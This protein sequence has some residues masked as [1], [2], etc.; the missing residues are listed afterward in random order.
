MGEV[1]Q[2]TD[3]VLHREVAVK[4]LRPEFA[5]DEDGLARFRAEA[6]HAGSL[7]HP[8][9]AHVYDYW[10]A[11]PPEPGHLVME[12]VDGPSLARILERGPLDPGRTMDIVAQAARGLAAAHGTGLVHRDIKPGNLLIRSDGLLK[13]TD[14]GI[15]HG[16]GEALVT[17][18]GALIGT[19]AYLAP[20]RAAGASATPAADLYS[21]GV[22]AHHCLTGRM[23]FEGEPLAVAIAHV[24]RGMPPLP[25]TVPPGVAALVAD[26]TSKI[27]RARPSAAEVALRAAQ[28]RI[29]LDR[30]APVA[31]AT[32]A[33]PPDRGPR[34]R[35][36]RAP[37]RNTAGPSARA[38]VA[39]AGI[40]AAGL[41]TWVLAT[42]PGTV[43]QRP[44]ALGP[45]AA[46][47][48]VTAHRAATRPPGAA[49]SGASGVASV[50][51][52]DA[53]DRA[54]ADVGAPAPSPTVPPATLA[55]PSA[56]AT[57]SAPAPTQPQPAATQP[58]PTPPEPSPPPPEPSP[59]PPEPSQPPP[60]PSQPPPAATS[61]A[62]TS[63]APSPDPTSGP[64][65]GPASSPASGPVSS[66]QT[67][68]IDA[69]R[70]DQMTS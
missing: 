23:P 55:E 33:R 29:A 9:I 51:P 44:P 8:N 56:T 15:S 70:A 37:R 19:P 35:A 6:H 10:E 65:S 36:G 61:P 25:T 7:S 20:E 12:L 67:V 30:P 41:V 63:P 46:S 22:V 18:T 64:A 34:H 31:S 5:R 32:P 49:T 58:Q 50:G 1:W 3:L 45:P 26:L 17:Q 24:E 48:R 2:G 53:A 60:E 54:P 52:G 16:P 38:A 21:L 11:E 43:P 27:P 28:L 66:P 57:Q 69:W 47:R 13:I 40:G 39:L 14:F 68:K 59:P 4:L 62:A 42:M